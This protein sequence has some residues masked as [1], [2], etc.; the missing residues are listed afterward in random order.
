MKISPGDRVA[1]FTGRDHKTI[2]NHGV[3]LIPSSDDQELT[4]VFLP[5]LNKYCL[6]EDEALLR[7][8]S[9]P[10]NQVSFAEIVFDSCEQDHWHGTYQRLHENRNSFCFIRS[11][12]VFGFDFIAEI[13]DNG[14]QLAKCHLEIR[15]PSAMELDT[16]GCLSILRQILRVEYTKHIESKLKENE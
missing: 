1:V 11:K 12:A 10:H 2:A 4:V 16:M 6:A 7:F 5:H 8:G 15:V 3:V 14:T 13:A 9:G